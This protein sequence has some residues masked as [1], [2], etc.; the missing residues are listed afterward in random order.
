MPLANG[1]AL[2]YI[3]AVSGRRYGDFAQ[4]LRALQVKVVLTL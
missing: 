3:L 2:G 1:Q 4:T